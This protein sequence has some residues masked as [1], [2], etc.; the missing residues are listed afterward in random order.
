M[1]VGESLIKHVKALYN[2]ISSCI[3]NNGLTSNYFSVGRG[4][5]QRDPLSPYSFILALEV[6]SCKIRKDPGIKGISV[7]NVEIT[8][9]QNADDTTCTL[10]NEQSVHNLLELLIH[11]AKFLD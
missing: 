3:M 8:I 11:L 7:N 4:V 5:R 6:C 2:N 9:I 10:E 1:N